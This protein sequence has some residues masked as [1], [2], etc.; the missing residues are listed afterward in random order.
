MILEVDLASR[1]LRVRRGFRRFADTVGVD[2]NPWLVIHAF[3]TDVDDNGRLLARRTVGLIA[4]EDFQRNKAAL[5]SPRQFAQI[6]RNIGC[7]LRCECDQEF[8]AVAGTL[9]RLNS[10]C[11]I[12]GCSNDSCCVDVRRLDNFRHNGES[13]RSWCRVSNFKACDKVSQLAAYIIL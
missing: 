5:F 8:V 3:K 6:I 7:R 12:I 1:L 9:E 11:A 4:D 2:N 13:R 10:Q